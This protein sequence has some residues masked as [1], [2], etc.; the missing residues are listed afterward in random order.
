MPKFQRILFVGLGGAGQRHLRIFQQLLPH[1]TEW[2]AYRAL[3]KTPLLNADFSTN[4]AMTIE[5]RYGLHVFSSLED[6]LAAAPDLVVIA[7]P[8][9]HHAGVALAA[10]RHGVHLFVEKP[11]SHTLDG[12]DAVEQLVRQQGLYFFIAFQRRFHPLLAR[13]KTLL[14]DGVVG[15][16]VNV[17]MNVGSYLPAWHPY[18]DFQTLYACR[19]ELGG[20]VLLTEIHEFDLCHWFFGL[21][22][23]V[24]CVG[25]NFSGVPM[26]VED[27][28]A[29]TLH[30]GDF[31][32]HINM[33][34]MQR[35]VERNIAIEGTHG[36]IAWT[37]DG[38][39]LVWHNAETGHTDELADAAYDPDQM[40]QAQARYFL[41]QMRPEDSTAQLANAR[42]SLVIVDAAKQ[43]MAQGSWARLDPSAPM[44]RLPLCS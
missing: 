4:S 35:R 6:A 34:F 43:S 11:F 10:A 13:I 25:G 19:R 31:L 42:G 44:L 26:D 40:F 28:A 37:S 7:T 39:R 2:C 41:Q 27:T 1:G 22:Q 33:S 8:T 23:R 16:V 24:L 14:D 38:N 3:R 30:Y 18:E 15:R 5:A 17:V 21:P 12:F 20:G 36:Y 29:A 9:A 32:A